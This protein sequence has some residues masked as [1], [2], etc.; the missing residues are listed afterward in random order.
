MINDLRTPYWMLRVS[1]ADLWMARAGSFFEVLGIGVTLGMLMVLW[2]L[3]VGIVAGFA[4]EQLDSPEATRVFVSNFAAI[5]LTD[6][7]WL[8]AQPETGFVQP[9]SSFINSR[10]DITS[11]AGEVAAALMMP[12]GAGDPQLPA[13]VKVPEQ[14]E[15]VVGDDVAIALNIHAGDRVR[16]ALPAVGE[17]DSTTVELTVVGITPTAQW[18]DRA[19]L[20]DPQLI[21]AIDMRGSVDGIRFDGSLENF[22]L[23]PASAYTTIRLYARSLDAVA[24]LVRKLSANGWN[25]RSRERLITERNALDKGTSII[26]WLLFLIAAVALSVG[27]IIGLINRSLRLRIPLSGLRVWGVSRLVISSVPLLQALMLS[28]CAWLVAG[29]TAYLGAGIL[30]ARLPAWLNEFGVTGDPVAIDASVVA[31][32]AGFSLLLALTAS[33]FSAF[34]LLRG[35][36]LTGG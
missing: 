5:S 30:N 36:D 15:A 8:R 12:T 32:A 3:K 20:L 23:P 27:N 16:L 17:A 31:A 2:G 33:I 13:G 18:Y 22:G 21:A 10:V 24:P 9:D 4:S 11:P 14:G 34:M 35:D 26:F 19:I 1:F 29:L 28:V 7:Q 6:L 25:A